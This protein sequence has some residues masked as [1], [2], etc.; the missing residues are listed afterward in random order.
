MRF[1]PLLGVLALAACAPKAGPP[2]DPMSLAPKDAKLAEL[3]AGSCKACHASGEG[4]APIVQD[5]A[6]WDPRWK[7]GEDVLL[8]HVVQGYRAMPALGQC[9]ACTPED[10]QALTRFLAGRESGA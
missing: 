2:A 8:E 10:F 5:R 1:I 4:G 6:A 3:Y 7:Q 9:A